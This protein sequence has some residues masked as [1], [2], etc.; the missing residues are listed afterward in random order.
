MLH[1]TLS[2]FGVMFFAAFVGFGLT[3]AATGALAA[4]VGVSALAIARKPKPCGTACYGKN[5]KSAVNCQECCDKS[6]K[7]H[8]P[9]AGSPW[10]TCYLMCDLHCGG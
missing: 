4:N 8:D 2:T 7:K 6:C 3:A 5:C 1:R 10:N 9:K